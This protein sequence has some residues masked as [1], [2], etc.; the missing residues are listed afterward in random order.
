MRTAISIPDTVFEEAERLV[1]ELQTSRS[2]L[3][4]RA[5]QEFVARHS[6][7][8]LTE[9][10]NRVIDEIG[11]EVDEFSRRAGRS[12]LERVEW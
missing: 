3:Y 5:L 12:V 7:E 2:Q 8:R 4:S 10:M 11:D 1:A 9:A 6:P